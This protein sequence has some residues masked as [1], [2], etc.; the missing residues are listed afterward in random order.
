VN[1]Q[2]KGAYQHAVTAARESIN[3]TRVAQVRAL[4]NRSQRLIFALQL[5]GGELASDLSAALLLGTV[6]ISVIRTYRAHAG[7]MAWP[8]VSCKLPFGRILSL[9]G[10][11]ARVLAWFRKN[12]S[13]SRLASGPRGSV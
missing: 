10:Y 12:R 9:P 11:S 4:S 8:P 13:I 7:G 1:D 5:S 6:P 2:P 3:A